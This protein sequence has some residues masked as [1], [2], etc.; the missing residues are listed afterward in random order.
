MAATWEVH[1][2]LGVGEPEG[3]MVLAGVV[4]DAL[5]VTPDPDATV[6]EVVA[7]PFGSPAT[8]ALLRVR[9]LGTRGEP[10]SLF[11]KVLQHVRHWPVLA[12]LPPADREDFLAF[13]PWRIELDLWTPDVTATLPDGLRPPHLHR[14]VELPDDRAVLWMEDVVEDPEPWGLERFARAARLLGRWNARSSHPDVLAACPLPPGYALRKYGERAVAARGLGPLADDGLWAH[15]WLADHADLRARLTELAP[16]IPT[17]LDRLDELPQAMPHGDASPQNLLVPAGDREGFVVI[18]IS[19][20]SPHALGFDLGQ[21]VV[22]LVHADLLPA[23]ALPEVVSMVEPAYVAGLADEGLT[24]AADVVHEAFTTS[25]MV[26]SGFDGLRLELLAD[27]DPA[28]RAS[29][30]QR[31]ALSRFLAGRL[32]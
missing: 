7:Y 32:A 30:D 13:F 26:R 23:A 11:A 5:G 25:A 12:M 2:L 16:R 18:D 28:H 8:A 20:R 9:G 24:G 31:V 17:W 3:A 19:F 22:G 14:L 27:A 15:P 21:L 10:W 4:E 1:D 29:F 6:V